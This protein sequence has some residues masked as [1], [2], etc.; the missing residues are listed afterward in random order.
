[1]AEA[2]AVVGAIAA[3]SQLAKY[4]TG[5]AKFILNSPSE[6]Q[7]IPEIIEETSERL[8][9][10]LSI[11]RSLNTNGSNPAGEPSIQPIVRASIRAASSMQQLLTP[12]I[13]YGKQTKVKKLKRILSY[14]RR[15][16]KIDRCRTDLECCERQLMLHLAA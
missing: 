3:C 5:L 9:W 11:V 7:V 16:R 1:M 12:L 15:I 4:G 14:Q 13:V 8:N 2:V 6:L 10:H